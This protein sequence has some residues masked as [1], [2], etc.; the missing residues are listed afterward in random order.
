M[1]QNFTTL[2][3]FNS[4]FLGGTAACQFRVNFV[5]SN[6]LFEADSTILARR[7]E[8]LINQFAANTMARSWQQIS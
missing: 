6:R 8:Y 5:F 1:T 3:T 7:A 2:V 4:E